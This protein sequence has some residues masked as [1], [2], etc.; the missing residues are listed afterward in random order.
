MFISNMQPNVWGL[1]T[2]T[3]GPGRLLDKLLS[4][5]GALFRLFSS[6][7]SP[8]CLSHQAG[9][10]LVMW[11][12]CSLST[13]SDTTPFIC[14]LLAAVLGVV[15]FRQANRLS[16]QMW[17]VDAMWLLLCLRN[18]GRRQTCSE[19]LYVGGCSVRS[20]NTSVPHCHKRTV[21]HLLG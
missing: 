7:Y 11:L 13:P 20:H 6:W 21:T 8:L 18:R 14:L 4:A 15:R 17:A 10:R 5:Q 9:L 3:P 16:G 1:V 2:T 19:R 12:V